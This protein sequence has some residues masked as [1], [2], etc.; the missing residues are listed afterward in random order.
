VKPNEFSQYEFK[1]RPTVVY[2]TIAGVVT[3]ASTGQPLVA[4]IEFPN[5]TLS[6]ITTDTTG[7]FHVA[8]VPAGAYTA[9]ATVDSYVRGTLPI[10]VD[11]GR[12]A[13]VSFSLNPTAAPVSLIGKT[14]DK[15]TGAPVAAKV[16][17]PNTSIASV[18][19]DSGTG[20]YETRLPAGAYAVQV[21]AEGYI[22]QTAAVVLEKDKPLARDFE[23]VKEGMTITLRGI[24]F[25]AGNATIKPE[26][27]PS[28]DD[29]AKILNDNPSITVEIQGH[30]DS[31]GSD[32]YNLNL[33][34]Q[35]ARSI[36]DYLTR[37]YG[38]DKTRLTAKGY[39][40]AK[41]IATND[42]EAGRALNRRVEFVI[43]K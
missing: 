37:N 35:R 22:K 40:E 16:S 6:P 25:D 33:S 8:G 41:P 15:K 13:T 14:S 23:L 24:Y 2:S 30:T 7:T 1:L 38:I 21:E 32:A 10:V 3:D 34:N 12:S 27:K 4:R 29:A 20:V 39:G 18:T 5:S 26:S 11:E 43:L 9:T 42:T 19:A 36:V 31:K 28:L 17:F